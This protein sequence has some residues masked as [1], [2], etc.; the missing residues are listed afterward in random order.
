MNVSGK[1]RKTSESEDHSYL[2]EFGSPVVALWFAEKL[3]SQRDELAKEN[4]KL[5]IENGNL[6]SFFEGEDVYGDY[7]DWLKEIEED[8]EPKETTK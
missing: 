2:N 7:L 8:N 5:K 4:L 6:Q 3:E 1:T